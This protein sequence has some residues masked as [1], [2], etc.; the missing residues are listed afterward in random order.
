MAAL[1]ETAQPVKRHKS[2]DRFD[3]RI[4]GIRRFPPAACR[5]SLKLVTY[6]FAA[7]A[8]VLVP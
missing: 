5:V 3:L 2:P 4:A 6:S 7:P 1:L 8:P